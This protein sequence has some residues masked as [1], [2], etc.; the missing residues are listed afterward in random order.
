MK[1][2]SAPFV[3]LGLDEIGQEVLVGPPHCPTGGPCVVIGTVAPHIDHCIDRGAAAKH[4]AT[5]DVGPPLSEGG[6]RL[7][8]IVPVE[9]GLEELREGSRDLDLRCI[10]DRAGFEQRNPDGSV[11]TQTGR[12][13]ASGGAG[14]DNHIVI[15]VFHQSSPENLKSCVKWT[16]APP[17]YLRG[18]RALFRSSQTA[19]V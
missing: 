12:E 11:L 5:G 9:V 15:L 1:T 16:S 13:N 17:L 14:T 2:A 7:R 4:L 6:L 18:K 8:R 3:G 19:N 10:I